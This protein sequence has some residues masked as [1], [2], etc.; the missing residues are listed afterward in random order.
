MDNNCNKKAGTLE[1]I[2][3]LSNKKKIRRTLE[4]ILRL[5]TA[6]GLL[7]AVISSSYFIFSKFDINFS[8]SE[9]LS[10]MI[11]ITGVILSV[12][13]FILL[14][15]MRERYFMRTKDINDVEKL[16][17]FLFEWELFESEVKNILQ[18]K[19][20]KFNENSIKDMINV[21][22]KND[23]ITE[24]DLI[25]IEK[26]LR[27]RNFLLHGNNNISYEIIGDSVDQIETIVLK[28]Q[29]QQ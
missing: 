2:L 5:Y 29:K 28:I 18:K 8:N 26:A 11:S 25:D 9:R 10:I 16:K 12:S 6:I 7:I 17:D 3:R 1:V 20:Y 27:I 4:S 13:S 22:Y 23:I 24:Y 21:L 19:K 15:T 14:M